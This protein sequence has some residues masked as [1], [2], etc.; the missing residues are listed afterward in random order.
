MD[1]IFDYV[2]LGAFKH[3]NMLKI[4]WLGMVI[5]NNVRCLESMVTFFGSR[6]EVF[7]FIFSTPDYKSLQ[8]LS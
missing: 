5:Q 7:V 2:P 6:L 8:S 3:L 1:T 4:V